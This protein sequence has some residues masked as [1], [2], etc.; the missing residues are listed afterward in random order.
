MRMNYV[1]IYFDSV[2]PHR[3]TPG[4]AGFD[5]SAYDT[6]QIK[7]QSRALIGVGIKLKIPDG[8]VGLIK[9]RSGLAFRKG[10]VVG[11]GILDSDYTGEVKVLLFNL[12][13]E[14]FVVSKGDK[15]AQLLIQAVAYPELK[16]VSQLENT[17]RGEGGFGSTGIQ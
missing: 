1:K 5:L 4:S 17:E 9:A 3:A 7:P 8:H 14:M 16:R 15:I 11:A 12:S 6:A 13:E 2:A 10:I